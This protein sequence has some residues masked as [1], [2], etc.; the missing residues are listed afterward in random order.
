MDKNIKYI[1]EKIQKFNPVEYND[2][3]DNQ[4]VQQLTDPINEFL[5]FLNHQILNI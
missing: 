3:I 2:I 5:Q 1:I 4:T